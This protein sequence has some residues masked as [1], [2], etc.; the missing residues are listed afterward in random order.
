MTQLSTEKRVVISA[1]EDSLSR[2]VARRLLDRLVK[3][4]SAGKTSHILLSG[5]TTAAAMLR[6]AGADSRRQDVDWSSV[7][8]WWGDERFVAADSAERND[9][10]ARAA[11]L[12]RIDVPADNIHA[13]PSTE[14]GLDLD[15]AAQAYAADLA[16]FGTEDHP[17]PA[18]YVCFL[19]VGRDG[20]I[21]SLFPDRGEIQVV[22]RSVVPVHDAP[23]PPASRLTVTRPV[24]NSARCVWMVLAGVDKAA[25]LGLAL[26]GASY[27][28]VPAAGAKGVKRTLLFVDQAAA[29]QVPPE[30][31]DPEF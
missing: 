19:G 4:S 30:L 20:H 29:G 3:R 28:T 12:S 27:D 8:F 14:S 24:L 9:G 15:A 17:W 22:D 10:T 16:A 1:D 23:M 6:A 7:H 25:A 21:A 2:A 31:I 26:A 18:F 11:F 5:G 13:M